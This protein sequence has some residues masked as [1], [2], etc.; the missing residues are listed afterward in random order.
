MKFD[1]DIII[2]IDYDNNVIVTQYEDYVYL[3]FINNSNTK[4]SLYNTS[5][6]T[7]HI[8]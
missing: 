2:G 4:P 5:N 7:I 3:N 8:I 1:G 6:N